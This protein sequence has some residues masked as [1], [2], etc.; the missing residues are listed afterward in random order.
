MKFCTHFFVDSWEYD[1]EITPFISLRQ[2]K[3]VELVIDLNQQYIKM[4]CLSE[5]CPQV[6]S[7]YFFRHKRKKADSDE[8][9]N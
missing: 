2:I 5:I 3:M 1:L 6:N 7:S 4:E 9:L 8:E